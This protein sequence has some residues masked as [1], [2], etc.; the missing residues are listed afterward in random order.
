M[1]F[2]MAPDDKIDSVKYP[3]DLLESLP[4]EGHRHKFQFTKQQVLRHGTLKTPLS[5]PK[6]ATD[7]QDDTPRSPSRNLTPRSCGPKTT[8]A[9]RSTSRNTENFPP[10]R[11]GRRHGYAKYFLE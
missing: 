8:D 7:D 5:S 11:P 6:F 4:L 10:E 2:N 1:I 3:Q 9:T